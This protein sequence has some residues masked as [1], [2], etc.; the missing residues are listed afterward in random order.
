MSS[1]SLKFDSSE[2]EEYSK[3]QGAMGNE[4]RVLHLGP[5][6]LRYEPKT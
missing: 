4:T 3:P 5:E 6:T 2:I 1:V